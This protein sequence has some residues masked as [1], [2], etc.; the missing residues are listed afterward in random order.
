[1]GRVKDFL[2]AVGAICL[3]LG[4][5]LTFMGQLGFSPTLGTETANAALAW[6]GDPCDGVEHPAYKSKAR[7]AVMDG[8]REAKQYKGLYVVESI[9][10]KDEWAYVEASPYQGPRSGELKAYILTGIAN[11]WGLKWEGQPGAL[12][13]QQDYPEGFDDNL[14]RCKQVS[15]AS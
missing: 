10:V 6:L 15:C 2:V 8:I 4:A 14:L 3:A 12:P 7:T 13:G 1:V 5:V 9:A 11:G